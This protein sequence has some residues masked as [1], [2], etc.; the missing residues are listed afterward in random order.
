MR[1]RL[2][3]R[4]G[5]RL[6]QAREAHLNGDLQAARTVYARLH[7]KYPRNED[8]KSLLAAAHLATGKPA[9]A[10]PML[11]GLVQV[12]P[13]DADLHYNLGVAHAALDN[14]EAA[15]SAYRQAI[16]VDG[17]HPRAHY[18]LGVALRALGLHQDA[19]AALRRD[20]A[21][22]PGLDACRLL[23]ESSA[24]AD[25]T[26]DALQFADAAV[27]LEGATAEDLHRLVDLRYQASAASACVSP[28]DLGA[29]IALGEQAVRLS[30][31]SPTALML[32]ARAYTQAGQFRCALPLLETAV[33]IQP[34]DSALRT[35]YGVTLCTV[36]EIEEGWKQ[37]TWLDRA[38]HPTNE[39]GVPRWSGEDEPGA[40]LLVTCEQGVGD[41]VLYARLLPELAG[42]GLDV[43]FQCDAR[44][45]DLFARTFPEITVTAEVS[46]AGATD[47][48]VPLG[49]LH[50]H[51]DLKARARLVP[52]ARRVAA[53]KAMLP[54][55]RNVGLSWLSHSGA[56]GASKSLN[57][58]ELAPLLELP[59]VNWFDLQY[60]EGDPIAGLHEAGIDL[61]DDLDGL[62]A[63]IAALDGVV[64]VSNATAHVAAAVGVDTHVLVGQRPVWHWLDHGRTLSW[65]PS[66]RLHRQANLQ[67]WREPVAEIAGELAEKLSGR[68][69]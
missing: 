56:N 68:C 20:Y 9:E 43:T 58:D 5:E 59:D 49:E 4:D 31:S 3:A 38:A 64:T 7:R 35:L 37:R 14:W 11:R 69:S 62:A 33:Q 12:R 44:L 23:R 25:E 32:G 47:W 30:P 39:Q 10:L 2:S 13:N 40:R 45:T 66:A 60:G 46:D 65:Y 57:Q 42:R 36:G 18:N 15:A 50:L 26:T 29:L 27:T 8:V 16:A 48:F 53:L 55:G 63:L 24:E 6:H 61:T 51:T 28:E 54:A 34:D 52:D 41:Q 67:G 1:T 19:L 22:S 21:L 17:D